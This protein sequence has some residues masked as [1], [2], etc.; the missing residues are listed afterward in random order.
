[1]ASGSVREAVVVRSTSFLVTVPSQAY[2][3]ASDPHCGYPRP[4]H[5]TTC[6]FNASVVFYLR[7]SRM[8]L[9]LR[10]VAFAFVCMDNVAPK[11]E[12]VQ[13]AR[14]PVMADRMAK[15]NMINSDPL[16]VG[17]Q[18]GTAIMQPFASLCTNP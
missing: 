10:T 4:K 9:S 15:P 13:P 18:L 6:T 12:R 3:T 8:V 11:H 7:Y 5:T 17:Q 1:M 14:S 2:R 16:A